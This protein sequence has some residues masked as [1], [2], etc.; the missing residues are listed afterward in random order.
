MPTESSISAV[1]ALLFDNNLKKTNITEKLAQK[2]LDSF[3]DDLLASSTFLK[4]YAL[5]DKENN[6]HEWTLAEAKLRWATAIAEVDKRF[7][8]PQDIDYFLELYDY[9]LPAGRQMLALGNPYIEK[10]TLN[11]CYTSA[12]MEDSLEG[13]FGVALEIAKTFSYAGGEGINLAPLRPREAIVSNTAGS[14][15]GSVSFGEMF[16]FITG[17]IGQ[18]GRRGA[19]MLSL[20]VWHPDIEEFITVKSLDKSRLKFANLSVMIDDEFMRCVEKDRE[21]TLYFQTKHQEICRKVRARDIWNLIIK[22]AHSSAEPGILFWDQIKRMS[23][24]DIY[25][26]LSLTGTNPCITG[27]TLVYTAD[28]R[29][30]VPIR[31]L[32]E[33]GK[34]V[35]VFCLDKTDKPTVRYMRNPRITGFKQPVYKVTLDDGSVIRTTSNHKFY[36]TEGGEKTVDKLQMGDSLKI[37][38]RFESSIN[39]VVKGYEAKSQNYLWVKVGCH[40]A[41]PEHRLIAGFHYNADMSPQVGLVVHHQDHNGKN[42][43]PSNLV[44][45]TK[46]EHD[47]THVLKMFGDNNP[48]RRAHVEWGAKQW[49]SYRRK[50]SARS[51]GKRNKNCSG[52]SND[53]LKRHAILLTKE[54]GRRFSTKEWAIYANRHGLV[55]YFSKWRNDHLGGVVGLA[56]WAAMECG[57]EHY[58]LEPRKQRTLQTLS[59]Q[60]YNCIVENNEVYVVKNC[61]ICGSEFK[62]QHERR[63]AGICFSRECLQQHLSRSQT[64]ESIEKAKAAR[65]STLVKQK[66]DNAIKM[67]NVFLNLKLSLKRAPTYKELSVECKKQNKRH[68]LGVH[69][70]FKN[71]AELKEFASTYNH[72]VVSVEFDGYEDVYNGTVDEFHNFMVGGF[73][74]K[75]ASGKAK[76]SYLVNPQCGELPLSPQECCCLGSL[77]LNKFVSKPFSALQSFDYQKFT[78]MVIRAV[79]HLDDVVELGAS[80][81]PLLEQSEKARLGRRIGLGVTGLADMFAALGME[82]DCPDALVEEDLIFEIKRNWETCA[83][84]DLAKQRGSFPL[85]NKDKHYEQGFAATLPDLIK[86][87]AKLH[88]QRNVDIATVAPNGSVA[89]IAQTTGGIEPIFAREYERIT[90]LDGVRKSF[91]VVH[92]GILRYKEITGKDAPPELFPTAHEINWRDRIEVQSI[93]QKYTGASISST[94]NLPEN[95]SVETVGE[96]YLTAWKRGLKGV[97]VYRENSRE[98]ILLAKTAKKTEEID[99][100]V[101]KLVAEGGDKFYIHISY[102]DQDIKQP[103]QIFVTNYKANENDRFRKL[104]GDLE[105]GLDVLDRGKLNQ[106]LER[107]RTS[108]ERITRLVSLGLKEGHLQLLIEILEKHSFVGTLAFNLHSI[109]KKS[110]L[111]NSQIVCTSCGSSDLIFTE[112]CR[113]CKSCGYSKCGG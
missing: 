86:E 40:T 19:L 102:R 92:P 111:D 6:I 36:L 55:A 62:V 58:D 84:I 28:G 43:F 21:Y 14:S 93:A 12:V 110:Y 38:T 77:L 81:H 94:I 80:K 45:M 41:Y 104:A 106:Q 85:F 39:E 97:T 48:M 33:E 35:P 10:A 16:S 50:Q 26:E 24:S 90:E 63:E 113:T 96:I 79:R 56:K 7:S 29:G 37:V 25:P 101:Y 109:L 105:R 20:P 103:Y 53:E 1:E 68:R 83:S 5:R 66:S 4:K 54:V 8:D 87:D 64:P 107:S 69:S 73:E 75:A 98:G 60:G 78:H 15:T 88:G 95:T 3:K 9:F 27:E 91:K 89:I 46:Q 59:C 17:I 42:N 51:T 76:F 82:Y 32:A 2:T 18:F 100:V 52:V 30:N 61:E 57:I 31:Q 65:S 72:R 11:N 22:A 71:Y 74:G 112:G 49:E 67:V 34:D 70:Y 47:K 23:S 13:I 44:V 99:T 108:L